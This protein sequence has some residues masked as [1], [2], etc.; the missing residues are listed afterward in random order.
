MRKSVAADLASAV[1]DLGQGGFCVQ[2]DG[3]TT[4]AGEC[5]PV[6]VTFITAT[7]ERKSLVI[8]VGYQTGKGAQNGTANLWN[9]LKQLRVLPVINDA[10]KLQAKNPT[11]TSLHFR[12]VFKKFVEKFE[13]HQH[14][15]RPPLLLTMKVKQLGLQTKSPVSN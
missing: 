9:Q 8:G 5:E 6:I 12:Q 11:S 15:D 3:V 7:L 14:L 13:T 2:V 1:L 4:K 10:L